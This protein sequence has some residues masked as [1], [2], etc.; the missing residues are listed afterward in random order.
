MLE[1]INLYNVLLVLL[2]YHIYN[3]MYIFF[4]LPILSICYPSIVLFLEDKSV[5][6]YYDMIL[7]CHLPVMLLSLYSSHSIVNYLSLGILFTQSINVGY[8]LTKSDS[9]LSQQIGKIMLWTS[10]CPNTNKN[11]VNIPIKTNLY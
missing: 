7:Y 4:F 2:G 11:K 9:S 6:W 5:N 1:F 10:L 3:V 8:Q